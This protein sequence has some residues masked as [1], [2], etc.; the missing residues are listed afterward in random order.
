MIKVVNCF[1]IYFFIHFNC[2]YSFLHIYD[3]YSSQFDYNPHMYLYCDSTSSS[4]RK[5]IKQ[6]IKQ[7]NKHSMSHISVQIIQLVTQSVSESLTFIS[8]A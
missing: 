8:A 3:K 4:I 2:N 7:K 1:F 5:K 6:N